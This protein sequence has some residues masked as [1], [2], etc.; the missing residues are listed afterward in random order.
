MTDVTAM[1]ALAL[2]DFAVA[3]SGGPKSPILVIGVIVL[4]LVIVGVTVAQ[5]MRRNR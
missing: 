5:F 3:A 4:A 2:H 1:P